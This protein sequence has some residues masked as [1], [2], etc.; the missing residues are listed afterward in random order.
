MGIERL[1]KRGFSRTPRSQR[2]GVEFIHRQK[3]S[4]R[5]HW[6]DEGKGI[7][8]FRPGRNSLRKRKYR[9]VW[10]IDNSKRTRVDGRAAKVPKTKVPV[11]PFF[12]DWLCEFRH[13][14]T[15][16]KKTINPGNPF[17]HPWRYRAL[18]YAMCIVAADMP[19]ARM[20][21]LEIEEALELVMP[22]RCWTFLGRWLQ[23]RRILRGPGMGKMWEGQGGL[24]RKKPWLL[25]SRMRVILHHYNVPAWS[26]DQLRAASWRN[27]KPVA[28]KDLPSNHQIHAWLG[29]L[30]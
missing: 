10:D 26:Y 27:Y 23:W 28:A 18:A 17:H 9:S 19:T 29:N 14:H 20:A 24:N 8:R 30:R 1:R 7:E 2:G 21:S 5:I 6:H 12:Y 22:V 15:Y 3:R 16:R 4:T 25:T 11:I 13:D